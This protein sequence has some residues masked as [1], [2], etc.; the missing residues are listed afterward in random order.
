MEVGI[1]DM[2]VKGTQLLTDVQSRLCLVHVVLV[3]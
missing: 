2:Y 1:E 3:R